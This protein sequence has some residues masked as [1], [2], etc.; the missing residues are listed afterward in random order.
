MSKPTLSLKKKKAI[1]EATPEEIPVNPIAAIE[2][3]EWDYTPEEEFAPR[4]RK[5]RKDKEVEQY[6]KESRWQ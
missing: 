5:R 4:Q 3:V 1:Q 6:R 2:I